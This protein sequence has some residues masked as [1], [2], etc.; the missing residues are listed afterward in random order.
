MLTHF[1]EI[2]VK[3]D[4]WKEINYNTKC[5]KVRNDLEHSIGLINIY[6]EMSDNCQSHR[7]GMFQ[8]FSLPQHSWAFK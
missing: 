7:L 1:Q 3:D 5:F 2:I 6:D 8:K 4:L